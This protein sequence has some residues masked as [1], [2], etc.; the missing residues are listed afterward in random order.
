MRRRITNLFG[1]VIEDFVNDMPQGPIL[2][3]AELL[4]MDLPIRIKSNEPL[5]PFGGFFLLQTPFSV[6]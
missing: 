1:N 6:G 4:L 5:S 3:S 2:R